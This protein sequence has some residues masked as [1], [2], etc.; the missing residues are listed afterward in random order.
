[1]GTGYWVLSGS[2]KKGV[3]ARAPSVPAATAVGIV[4][5]LAAAADFR[6]AE[7]KSCTNAFPGLTSSHTE[8]AAA[9]LR[10]GPPATALQPVV[11]GHDHDHEQ[12]LTPTDE[13]TWMSLMPRRAPRHEEAFDW[14]MLYSKLR[15][16][17]AIATAGDAPRPG[18]AAGAF[19]S[20]VSLHDVRLEPGSLYWR[21]QQTNLEYLLLLDVDRLV[22]SFR[23][24][25]GLTA[26]GTPYGGW[27]GPDVQLRGHFVGAPPDL[28]LASIWSIY[29]EQP[30]S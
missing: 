2:C 13:S 5:L 25:A 24:Q 16:A 8:R 10:P 6:G 18:A 9:Q 12:H 11:H 21:A 30:R 28:R 4:V 1:M 14:L 7:A 17:T 29:P 26:P 19:L 3:M 22:W 15:G 27:E 23:K 20:E